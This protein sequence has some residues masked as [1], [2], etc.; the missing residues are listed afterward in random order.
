[1][2]KEHSFK[3]VAALAAIVLLAATAANAFQIAPIPAQPKP[4]YSI[5]TTAG[6]ALDSIEDLNGDGRRDFIVGAESLSRVEVRSGLNGALLG[7]ILGPP[8]SDFGHDV[9]STGDVDGDGLEDILIG[10]PS[11]A[12]SGQAYLYSS[13]TLTPL[14]I[15]GPSTGA[16]GGGNYGWAVSR[17]GQINGTGPEEV[18]VTMPLYAPAGQSHVGLMEAVDVAVGTAVIHTIT[19]TTSYEELG[20][21]VANLGNVDADGINDFVIGASRFFGPT[22]IVC[23]PAN[24]PGIARVYSGVSL[25]FGP[26]AEV[27]LGSTIGAGPADTFGFAVGSAGDINNDGTGDLL[28]GAPDICPLTTPAAYAYSGA[29]IAGGGGGVV[30][31]W[32]TLVSTVNTC[33]HYGWA[34]SGVGNIVGA[35]FDEYLVSAPSIFGSCGNKGRVFLHNGRSGNIIYNLTVGAATSTF[36]YDVSELDVVGN[37]NYFIISDPNAGK[38]Y[39]YRL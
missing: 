20:D 18:L 19:G 6:G 21:S 12:S 31:P 23:Q 29:A 32:Q 1:M 17:A 11:D 24:I 16:G 38:V 15:W 33:L 27:L 28:V 14:R 35:N 5:N 39:V 4:W 3:R 37:R 26:G 13:A 9:A 22:G 7:V 36:G 10:A 2:I 30:A 34:V 25:N 8:F